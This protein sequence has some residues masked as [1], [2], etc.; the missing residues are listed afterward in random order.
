MATSPAG[1]PGRPALAAP[2]VA[3]A[4]LVATVLAASVA[5][6]RS[7][8]R[9]RVACVGD[10]ITEGRDIPDPAL[11][12][13]ARLQ[14]LLG[15]RHEVRNFGVGGATAL[16][17][18]DLPYRRQPP[19]ARALA[20]RPDVVV[21]GLGSND[22]KPWNWSGRG[23][24]ADDL[25]ALAETFRSVNPGARVILLLPP[26]VVGEGRF[27]IR[28]EV[29]AGEVAPEIDR[30]ARESGL[31]VVDLHAVLAGRLDL[32]P[33]RVHPDAEGAERI[34]RAVAAAILR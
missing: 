15:G 9:I 23:A 22:A 29:V 34:A 11:R 28:E 25:R 20:F 24:F 19:F 32:L 26:P 10:S 16:S 30:A 17:T 12:Y 6:H 1:P 13:P 7:T 4:A 33:D 27:G 14:A 2:F 31:E 18:G 3:I 5:A 21:I 8:P